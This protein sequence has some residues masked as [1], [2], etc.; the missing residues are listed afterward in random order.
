M[1]DNTGKKRVVAESFYGKHYG[2]EVRSD[3]LTG[4][5]VILVVTKGKS[6]ALKVS[7][8]EADD[9]ETAARA[10]ELSRLLGCAGKYV[11]R[12]ER[13]GLDVVREHHGRQEDLP[14]QS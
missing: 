6:S 9:E 1:S 8:Y 11:V 13:W 2:V 3:T 5:H 4:D 10:A 14:P 12:V 7:I